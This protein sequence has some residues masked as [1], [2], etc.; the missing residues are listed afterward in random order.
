[1]RPN[2]RVTLIRSNNDNYNPFEPSVDKSVRKTLPCHANN[3]PLH[4]VKELYGDA[5]SQMIRIYFPR[6]VDF[7]FD[8]VEIDGKEYEVIDV[9][10]TFNTTVVVKGRL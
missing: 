6:V 7:L 10:N 9:N 2:K 3:V 4:K 1:M 5:Y 8:K